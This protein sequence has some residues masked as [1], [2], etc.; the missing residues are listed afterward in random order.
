MPFNTKIYSKFMIM[1]YTD[2]FGYAASIL[3]I[4]SF[5]FQMYKVYKNK[6][7]NDISY[8]FIGLQLSVNIL[9]TVYEG[10]IMSIPLLVG[11]ATIIILLIIFSFET[12]YYKKL[13]HNKSSIVN[14][15]YSDQFATQHM[16]T[17]QPR[18]SIIRLE[19]NDQFP[20]HLINSTQ[21]MY[22]LN[23]TNQSLQQKDTRHHN[24][25]FANL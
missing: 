22:E 17:D 13:Y 23:Q 9:Q 11:N 14:L 18:S 15:D 2:G 12:Y 8:I 21:P 25:E 5:I 3:S 20:A 19:N 6:S 16:N 1:K 24:D 7:A 10:I 4:A